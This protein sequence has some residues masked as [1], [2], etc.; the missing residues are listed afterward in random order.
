MSKKP[1]TA[2]QQAVGPAPIDPAEWYQVKFRKLHV[3]GR[4]EYRPVFIYYMRG[5]KL[6]EMPS[7]KIGSYKVAEQVQN[8]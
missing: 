3:E 8:G 6:Q 1:N 5:A 4:T 2:P 7:D